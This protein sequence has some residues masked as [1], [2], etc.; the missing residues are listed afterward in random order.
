M[1]APRFL[2]ARPRSTPRVTL[3]KY[4]VPEDEAARMVGTGRERALMPLR[5]LL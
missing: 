4:V 5:T 2:R 1:G 3:A